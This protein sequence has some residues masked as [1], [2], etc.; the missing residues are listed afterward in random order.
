MVTMFW[1]DG[2]GGRV[3]SGVFVN[4]CGVHGILTCHH[5][6]KPLM[7]FERFALS[8]AD[9]PHSL[10]VE[11]RHVEHFV[12]GEMNKDEEKLKDGPDL[13]FLIIRDAHLLGIIKSKK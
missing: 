6:S 2:P 9:H 12:V 11:T 8:I 4:T 5:V 1:Q 7:E 10:W 3:G 13:S